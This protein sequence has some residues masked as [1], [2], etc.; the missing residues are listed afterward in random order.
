MAD[1]TYFDPDDAEYER[2]TARLTELARIMP[3]LIELDRL[4]GRPSP[5]EL[6]KADDEAQS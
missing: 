4:F 6:D 2:K 3:D 1:T 5:P